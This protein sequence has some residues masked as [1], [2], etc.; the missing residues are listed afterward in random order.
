[1]AKY[2]DGVLAEQ[3]RRMRRL[4]LRISPPRAGEMLG[5]DAPSAAAAN[6]GPVP[7]ARVAE[8]IS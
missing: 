7:A 4:L 1:V 3:G 8:H 6:M 2:P 5:E